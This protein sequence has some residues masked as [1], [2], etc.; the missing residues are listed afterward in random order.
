MSPNVSTLFLHCNFILIIPFFYTHIKKHYIYPQE[1]TCM[2]LWVI[3]PTSSS[4]PYYSDLA[5]R[6]AIVKID[7][8]CI[9]VEETKCAAEMHSEQR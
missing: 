5:K 2:Y 7:I 4:T 8:T 1:D 3:Q 6:Y 9:A